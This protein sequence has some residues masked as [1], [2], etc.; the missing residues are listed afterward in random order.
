MYIIKPVC[1]DYMLC[2]A[3]SE[4]SL[5]RHARCKV[6]NTMKEH[7]QTERAQN[8]GEY[9]HKRFERGGVGGQQIVLIIYINN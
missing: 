1:G 3:F 5:I 4:C 9:K 6:Q 2:S 8:R 7:K